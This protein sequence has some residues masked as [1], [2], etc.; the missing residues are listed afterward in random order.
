MT[1]EQA[2]KLNALVGIP[3]VHGN[4]DANGMSCFAMIY[5]AMKVFRGN[6]ADKIPME[7]LKLAEQWYKDQPNLIW[8]ETLKI[9]DEITDIDDLRESDV[10]MFSMFGDGVI[11]HMGVMVD[12]HRFIHALI[13][14]NSKIS[15]I[16]SRFWKEKLVKMARMR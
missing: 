5:Q 11:T 13:N 2:D 14:T 10:V 4:N 1:Q 9:A 3:C 16:R 12:E 6:D 7:Y 8:D 15:K